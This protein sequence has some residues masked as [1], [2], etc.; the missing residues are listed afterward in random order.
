VAKSISEILKEASS[1]RSIPERAEVLRTNVSDVLQGVLYCSFIDVK[2]E[3]PPGC[4][5]YNPSLAV[6]NYNVLAQEWRKMN[7]FI[8]DMY[9]GLKPLKRETLWVQLLESVTPDDAILLSKMKDHQFEELYKRI[10]REV[11]DKAFP[12]LL[13]PELIIEKV[14][15]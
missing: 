7:M 9:P 5:P 15:G 13:P 8:K 14:N 11:V 10:T 3:I 1:K 4:P 12:S 2:W 6:D